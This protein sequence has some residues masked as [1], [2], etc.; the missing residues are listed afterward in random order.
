ML[1]TLAPTDTTYV[2]TTVVPG[3]VQLP[4]RAV[5]AVG[6]SAYARSGHGDRPAAWLHDGRDVA[7]PTRR[8]SGR[9]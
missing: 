9:T 3:P 5:N 1:A 6:P 7:A 8:L 4:G 2:D